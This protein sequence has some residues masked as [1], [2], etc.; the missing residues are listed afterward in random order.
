MKPRI[1]K[2]EDWNWHVGSELYFAADSPESA[3][4]P[5]VGFIDNISGDLTYF[6]DSRVLK[7]DLPVKLGHCIEDFQPI[8]PGSW[9]T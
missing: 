2:I 6:D 7:E 9:W 3:A 8:K 1:K 4:K 5:F